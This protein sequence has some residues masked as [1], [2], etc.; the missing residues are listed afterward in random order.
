MDHKSYMKD[1]P[2]NGPLFFQS[3]LP[4]NKPQAIMILVHGF[5]EHSSRYNTH[6]AEFFTNSGI[7]IFSFD[8]PGHGK[9]HGKRGH[10]ANPVILLETIDLLVKQIKSEYPETPIFLYGHSFGGEVTLWYTLVR[11]PQLNGV[12]VTSPLIGPKDPVPFLKLLLAKIMDKVFPAF[13]M[14]NGIKTKFLSKDT[15]IVNAYIADPLV[16]RKI[17][18]RSGMMIIDRGQWILAHAD[19]NKNKMLLM[20]GSD[21]GIVNKES[22]DKFC[23]KCPYVTYKVWPGMYHELHNDI[24]KSQVFDFSLKW[25]MQNV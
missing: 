8:L 21:E 1:I 15:N 25:M 13:S 11:K 12:I 9:T 23:E 5:G 22:V 10:I 19:N 6:F 17:S 16:H 3:W 20:I 2:G 7:G 14:G 4:T 18:A 24:E